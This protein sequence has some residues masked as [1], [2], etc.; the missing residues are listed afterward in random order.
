[1]GEGRIAAEIHRSVVYFSVTDRHVAMESLQ[2]PGLARSHV[3]VWIA[4]YNG[5]RHSARQFAR[6]A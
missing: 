3:R 5:N 4:Q 2:N 1:M 6:P